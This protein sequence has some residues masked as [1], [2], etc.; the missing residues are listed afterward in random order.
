MAESESGQEKTEMPTPKRLQELLESGQFA[1]SPEIQTVFLIAMGLLALTMMMPHIMATFKIYMATIFSQLATMQVN[2]DNTP[3]I[4][5]DF[6]EMAGTCLLPIMAGAFMAGLMG[7]GLQSRFQLTPKALEPKFSKMNPIK[8]FKNIFS[9]Q[10][11]AKLAVALTKFI[12]IFGFT[13]PV[14]RDVMEDPIF[15]SSTDFSYLLYFMA[16][17]AQSVTLR[18]LAG[19]VLIAMGD[20]AYQMWKNER[21]SMMT[22]QEVKDETKNV[23]GNQQVKGEMRRRRRQMLKESMQQEVPEADV[24]VTNPTHLAVA[25]KYDRQAMGAP[26]V[27]AKGARYNALRIREIANEHDV[28][29]VENKPVARLLFKHCKAGQ[30]IIPQ[31][32]AVV[33]EILAHVYRVNRYRY[34]K[35]GMDT[36]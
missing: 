10:S 7:C 6:I 21:D 30:E 5:T 16:D 36:P 25:L 28:P 9:S 2:A 26:R 12:V 23:E 29:I 19:M 17:T 15:S 35:R 4:F 18:V 1:K 14:I 34:Y 27:V 13:W 32:Y 31:L 33:A 24:V 22:M 3:K 11:L 8:G 20:Y